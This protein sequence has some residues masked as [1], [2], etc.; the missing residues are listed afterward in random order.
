MISRRSSGGPSPAGLVATLLVALTAGCN[1][2]APTVPD[3]P[4]QPSPSGPTFH[5]GDQFTAT[6]RAAE[7][8]VDAGT[9]WL[10]DANGDFV[11]GTDPDANWNAR[12]GLSLTWK[13]VPGATKYRVMARNTL[14]APTAYRELALVPA[15]DPSLNP[16][17]VATG[18]NPW[19]AGLGT[20]GAPWSFTNHIEF[21]ISSEDEKGVLTTNAISAPL[22]T[23]DVYPGHV[24]G[25]E[26]D[27]STLPV[28]FDPQV[29]RGATF[30]KTIR[31]TF[32]E[33]MRTEA[34][35][36]LTSQSA[37]VNLRRVLSS[38]WG[39]DPAL[40]ANNPPS[41]AANAFL[42]VELTAN[43]PCTELLVGRSPG[44]VVLVLRDAS[45]VLPD[46][47]SRLVLLDGTTGAF[48]GEA[49]SVSIVNVETGQVGLGSPVSAEVPAGSLACTLDGGAFAVPRL[50]SE[51]G[52]RLSV[53]DA[54]PFFVGEQVAVH[55]PSAG[56]A[57]AVHDVRTVAG[58]DTVEKVLVLSE[59][60]SPGHGA[61]SSV[62]PLNGLGG[63][64]ALRPGADM[65]LVRDV[66]G[67]SDRELFVASPVSLMVGDTVLVD[68]DGRLGT[69]SDQAQAVV[70][71]VRFA[72]ASG[73]PCS[74][75]VDLPPA[76]L[77]LHGRAAVI[78]MG[79]SFGVGG[80]RDTTATAAIPLDAHGDQFSP[81]GRRY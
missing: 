72:P 59:P 16:T 22:D 30:T 41:A 37:N 1:A 47:A 77:L 36:T 80:T 53:T 73:T 3:E 14:T 27:L 70:K 28:P 15:P 5:L 61:A 33:P 58:V 43:G 48:L 78:G 26:I 68:G 74:L 52:T 60:L 81:D 55:E 75:V 66:I 38:T 54:T 4:E 12:A 6:Q 10:R 19:T 31:L 8:I 35:P 46:P 64:V 39:S 69:T 62:I 24:T 9:I 44:D 7:A 45:L 79:D 20:G 25:V 71:Q 13:Q 23:V 65:A 76:L 21:T 56:G 63:E 11:F 18:L 49:G 40:P 50:A 29:E 42:K 32:S 57:P 17:V 2:A 34:P 51:S 67:G